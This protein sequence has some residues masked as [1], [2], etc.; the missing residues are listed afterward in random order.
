MVYFS[1]IQ[2]NWDA[3]VHR[4]VWIEDESMT[5]ASSLKGRVVCL[6]HTL[7]TPLKAWSGVG[8]LALSTAGAVFGTFAI[9]TLNAPPQYVLQ[10]AANVIDVPVGAVLLPIALLANVIRGIAGTIFHPAL[11]IRR[12]HH[13]SP[14]SAIP[15]AVRH[16]ILQGTLVNYYVKA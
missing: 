13:L 4:T 3:I 5:K 1:N 12:Y 7:A 16:Y 11:M 6:T 9:L 8:T 15:F 14:D 10:I 2:R